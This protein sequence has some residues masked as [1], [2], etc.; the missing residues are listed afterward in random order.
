MNGMSAEAN[1]VLGALRK[2][3]IC[4]EYAPVMLSASSFPA[5]AGLNEV[6]IIQKWVYSGSYCPLTA[7][8]VANVS[9][10]DMSSFLSIIHFYN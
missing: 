10:N 1:I 9:T 2:P 4:M 8:H 7:M 5:A 6:S 3:V